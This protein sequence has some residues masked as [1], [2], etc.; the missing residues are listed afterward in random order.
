MN[1][2][3]QT[4]G[5]YVYC[6]ITPDMMVYIGMSKQKT[7]DRWQKS[8]Y[9]ETSLQPYIEKYEWDD[10]VHLLIEDGLSK[11][12]AERLEDFLITFATDGGFCINRQRSGG[13]TRDNFSEYRQM[14]RK[15][16][17]YKEYQKEYQKKYRK[18]ESYK[19]SER[20]RTQTQEYKERK[21]EYMRIYREKRRTTE[22]KNPLRIE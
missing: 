20:K 17:V 10:I 2:Y 1:K 18:T 7:Y 16:L 6:H 11:N 3:P 9:K 14:Q 13:L 22:T 15:S 19:E 5:Y 21:R 4:K 12:D 8:A